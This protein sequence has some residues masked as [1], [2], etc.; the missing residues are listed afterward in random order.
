MYSPDAPGLVDKLGQAMATPRWRQA[1]RTEVNDRES[2][3]DNAAKMVA[4]I[5]I[6]L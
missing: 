6:Q 2:A 3:E 1:A 5:A 4:L